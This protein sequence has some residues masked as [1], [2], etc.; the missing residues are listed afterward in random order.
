MKRSALSLAVL[1]SLMAPTGAQAKPARQYV[2]KHPKHEHC[3]ANYVRKVENVERREHRRTVK[4]RETFCVYVTPKLPAKTTTPAP[5]TSSPTARLRALDPSFTQSPA[6]PLIVTYSY[7]ASAEQEIGGVALPDPNLPSGVLAFYSD[8]LL[9]C[10]INVGGSV[11]GG[12]CTVSYSS[13]GTHTINVVYSSGEN[14]ATTG[15]ETVTIVEPPIIP[16]TTTQIVTSGCN[17]TAFESECTY[18]IDVS[19]TAQNG[20]TLTE[21]RIIDLTGAELPPHVTYMARIELPPAAAGCHVVITQ[22]LA[23]PSVGVISPDCPGPWGHDTYYAPKG[24]WLEGEGLYERL[25]WSVLSAYTGQSG[26]LAFPLGWAASQSSSQTL[27][28]E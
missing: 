13:F 6:N 10:S 27:P 25:S 23:S 2:L 16:T 12:Q 7:S 1:V 20:A 28:T 4:V 11:S 21:G 26:P 22:A 17:E 14:S 5:T 15:P 24:E 8:G 3:R 18:T 19:A 9:S